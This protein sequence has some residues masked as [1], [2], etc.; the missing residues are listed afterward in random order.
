MKHEFEE[1]LLRGPGEPLLGAALKASAGA[2]KHR[3][4]KRLQT[5]NLFPHLEHEDR[6]I[7]RKC[8]HQWQAGDRMV[9]R[10]R[11]RNMHIKGLLEADAGLRITSDDLT[12]Q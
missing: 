4:E 3:I 11:T 7:M 10:G 12:G 5:P 2:V 8:D 1:W 9:R 6:E